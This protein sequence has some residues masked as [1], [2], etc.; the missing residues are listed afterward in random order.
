LIPEDGVMA[1]YDP[2]TTPREVNLIVT[3]WVLRLVWAGLYETSYELER[4]YRE[5]L[6]LVD[7]DE[8][9]VESAVTFGKD[10]AQMI[11]S[12]VDPVN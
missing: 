7:C 5:R 1:A 3:A 11:R 2:K 6:R 10:A 4:S 8:V 12:Q 9:Y